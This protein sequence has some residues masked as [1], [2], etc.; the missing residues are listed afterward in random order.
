MN[1][2]PS[3]FIKVKDLIAPINLQ[4]TALCSSIYLFVE[5]RH[6]LLIMVCDIFRIGKVDFSYDIW[7]TRFLRKAKNMKVRFQTFSDQ[8]N[9]VYQ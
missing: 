1:I 6:S 7:K 3:V 2:K 9:S 4:E 8:I 5:N